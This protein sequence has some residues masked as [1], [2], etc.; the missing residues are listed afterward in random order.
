M[1]S[2]INII[3]FWINKRYYIMNLTQKTQKNYY[4]S[5]Y[6]KTLTTSVI[7]CVKI[8]GKY[9]VILKNTIFY[10]EG[11]GQPGDT[12]KIGNISVINTQIH[13]NQICHIV[14][15]PIEIDSKVEIELDWERRYEF[16]QAHTAQHL[17]SAILAK[18]WKIKTLSIHFSDNSTSIDIDRRNFDLEELQKL[19][20]DVNRKIFLNSPIEIRWYN[21]QEE[22]QELDLRKIPKKRSDEGFRIVSIEDIDY[23]ACGGTHVD[24]LG[25]I[26]I[27][28]F[29]KSTNISQG[30]RIEFVCG[31]RA[32]K[33]YQ[34]K[35]F[36]FQNAISLL[37]APAD[38]IY[39]NIERIFKEREEMVGKIKEFEIKLVN[40]EKREII[41]SAEKI[42]D[43]N[44]Y[45]HIFENISVNSMRDIVNEILVPNSKSVIIFAN[46]DNSG[47]IALLFARNEQ[48]LSEQ[49]NMGQILRETAKK[50]NGNGGGRPH[51]AQGGGQ[52]DQIE[53]L[54]EIIQ[55]VK[56][57]IK[58][59]VD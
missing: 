28:K 25:E 19:E 46:R 22:I 59:L 5:A 31:W 44:L 1:S 26:G 29:L 9:G 45:H 53:N 56:N 43:G 55:N 13:N 24:Q 57:E 15:I 51:F 6:H 39:A 7:E 50:C 35:V 21:T 14:E 4:D 8:K 42:V 38:E 34:N 48:F 54:V 30:S 18:F 2:K 37:Q 36:Q 41:S 16:M 10:P 32:L 58:Q 47:K 23:S 33:D 3:F 11:G 27:I 12:G 49:L 17:I 52:I 40:Y 20:I